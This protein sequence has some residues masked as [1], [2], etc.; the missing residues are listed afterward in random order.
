MTVD[1][2]ILPE[3]PT[4]VRERDHK[5]MPS[6]PWATEISVIDGKLMRESKLDPPTVKFIKRQCKG[7]TLQDLKDHF[8]TKRFQDGLAHILPP[9]RVPDP[10]LP[11]KE[12]AH[13]TMPPLTTTKEDFGPRG[14]AATGEGKDIQRI[15]E[16]SG[17]DLD[18]TPEKDSKDETLEEPSLSPIPFKPDESFDM[19]LFL[20]IVRKWTAKFHELDRC[21]H[22]FPHSKF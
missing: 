21:F 17:S 14:G 8:V 1:R 12:E 7:L 18:K 16:G 15:Q 11:R 19:D 5:V 4:Y 22:K 6:P 3:G 13:P 10:Q 20:A 9:E 2:V